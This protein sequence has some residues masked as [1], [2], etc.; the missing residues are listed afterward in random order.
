MVSLRAA[1]YYT[2]YALI[3]IVVLPVCVWY[4]VVTYPARENLLDAPSLLMGCIIIFFS[5]VRLMQ[6][7]RACPEKMTVITFY[8]F[9]YIWLG[10]API[11]QLG[12][13]ELPW[14]IV[15]D[16]K[17]YHYAYL[18]IIVSI[19]SFEFGYRAVFSKKKMR[20]VEYVP[21]RRKRLILFSIGAILVSLWL[22]PLSTPI[23]VLLSFREEV[24][25]AYG[26]DILRQVTLSLMRTPIYVA[27]LALL[28]KIRSS[29]NKNF[30]EVSLLILVVPVFLVVNFPTA[31]SRAWFGAISISTLLVIFLTS[32]R[33]LRPY[34][35]LVM[36]L[37]LITLFPF[38][39]RF[40]R[41]G[42]GDDGGVAQS[43]LETYSRG[44]F[45]V[46]SMTAHFAKFVFGDV[47]VSWG[48]QLL[49]VIFFWVPRS[50]WPGKPVG[51]GYMV[52]EQSGFHFY[53]V[54]APFWAEGL[55]NFSI[56]GV[57]AFMVTLGWFL[58]KLDFHVRVAQGASVFA[59]VYVYIAGFLILIMRG[60]LMTVMV[61]SVPFLLCVAFL[62]L[63]YKRVASVE[64][65]VCK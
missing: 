65:G 43:I 13:G 32:K 41:A 47:G 29:E 1:I 36:S 50:I 28:W 57:V 7:G 25:A 35:P 5:S 30:I 60:D 61:F 4:L 31:V 8:M 26:N 24:A 34:F 44:D 59:L 15:L 49:G 64:P 52:A 33:R 58:K 54:S 46:F 10:L 16:I 3:F 45:D 40:R 42:Y 19:L 23:S 56:L 38:M 53:N 51:S 55:V 17:Y 14:H 9:C 21:I 18:I 6:L 39:H 48:H 11:Y 37:A 63:G 62:G 2:V 27:L 22:G 12:V 20:E